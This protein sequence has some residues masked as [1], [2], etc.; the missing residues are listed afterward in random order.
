MSF[1][2]KAPADGENTTS[3][4]SAAPTPLASGQGENL[5][6]SPDSRVDAW[7]ALPITQGVTVDI[8]ASLSAY[9]CGGSRGFGQIAEPRSLLTGRRTART[10]VTNCYKRTVNLKRINLDFYGI[11]QTCE[12]IERKKSHNQFYPMQLCGS[13]HWSACRNDC[14]VRSLLV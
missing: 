14:K 5:G 1:E 13:R 9:S 11:F 2:G 6:R 3:G 4:S 8:P 12:C 10:E 7:P